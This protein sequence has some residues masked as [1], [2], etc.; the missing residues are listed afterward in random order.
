MLVLLTS[1]S[2]SSVE[3]YWGRVIAAIYCI[4][5]FV[6]ALVQVGN[7]NL[8]INFSSSV[9]TDPPN[10]NLHTRAGGYPA[11]SDQTS[12]SIPA[13]VLLVAAMAFVPALLAF[14]KVCFDF[15]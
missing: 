7:L 6:D 2:F 15:I 11:M 9:K 13:A 8:N 4:V 10:S 14:N 1:C 3:M 5:I 12:F